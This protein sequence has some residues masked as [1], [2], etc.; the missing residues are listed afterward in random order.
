[1][2]ILTVIYIVYA[3]GVIAISSG[4]LTLVGIDFNRIISWRVYFYIAVYAIFWPIS[5]PYL[6]TKYYIEE[7]KKK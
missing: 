5:M 4:F 7:V 1:M 3:V 2:T 6:L